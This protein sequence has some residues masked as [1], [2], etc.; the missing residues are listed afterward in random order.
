[1]NFERFTSWAAWLHESNSLSRHG[2]G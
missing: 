2:G 1:V